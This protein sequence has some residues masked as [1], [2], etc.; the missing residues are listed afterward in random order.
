[1]MQKLETVWTVNLIINS[2][3]RDYTETFTFNCCVKPCRG[4][5]LLFA[6]QDQEPILNILGIKTTHIK[7]YI[8]CNAVQMSLFI[9][10]D[11]LEAPVVIRA[12]MIS[13]YPQQTSFYN[14][15]QARL[16]S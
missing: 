4:L 3:S 8:T 16:V 12:E 6:F 1:M 11:K 10:D 14:I 2:P 13:P 9:I 15:H 5:E 7:D